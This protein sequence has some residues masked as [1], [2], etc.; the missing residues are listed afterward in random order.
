MFTIVFDVYVKNIAREAADVGKIRSHLLK[1]LE[2]EKFTLFW[3]SHQ[4]NMCLLYVEVHVLDES[5]KRRI[6][7]ISGMS[8]M[9]RMT[10]QTMS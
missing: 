6:I 7:I 8:E 5:E 4:K 2:E 9:W 1:L 3:S 10:S